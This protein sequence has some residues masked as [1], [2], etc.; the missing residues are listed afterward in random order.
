MA[1]ILTISHEN[2]PY[3]GHVVTFNLTFFFQMEVETDFSC[4]H[5]A[6]LKCTVMY[7]MI[8]MN[9]HES[10]QCF[11]FSKITTYRLTIAP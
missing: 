11:V 6:V 9:E 2:T 4:F 3:E 8:L 10:E 1:K 5:A 7:I